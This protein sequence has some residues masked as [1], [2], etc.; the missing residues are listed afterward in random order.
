MTKI[1]GV[2]IINMN[3]EK[4]LIWYIQVVF[5]YLFQALI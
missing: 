4:G 5:M 3:Y 2:M 1:S